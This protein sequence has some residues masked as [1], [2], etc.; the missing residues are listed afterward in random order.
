M[1]KIENA[2]LSLPMK[3]ESIVATEHYF[4]LQV[5]GILVV[6]NVVIFGVDNSSS[7]YGGNDKN[8]FLVLG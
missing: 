2:L 6:A 7:S 4:L 8:R 1:T 3:N 5:H